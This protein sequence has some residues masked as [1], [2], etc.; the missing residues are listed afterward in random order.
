MM[1][2]NNVSTF[3]VLER[4]SNKVVVL[5]VIKNPTKSDTLLNAMEQVEGYEYRYLTRYHTFC[6]MEQ[7]YQ[8]MNT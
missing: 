2:G 7:A 4:N 8:V 3:K 5:K 1:Y 6:V